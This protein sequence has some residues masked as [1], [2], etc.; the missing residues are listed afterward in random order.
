MLPAAWEGSHGR[1]AAPE[2]DDIYLSLEAS[3]TL[4]PSEAEDELDLGFT[5]V[6][7]IVAAIQARAWQQ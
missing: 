1:E 5:I 4:A 3:S 2:E 7:S 6:D